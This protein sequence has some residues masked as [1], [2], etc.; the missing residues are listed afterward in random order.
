MAE[1]ALGGQH[2]AAL[3]M[4]RD[5]PCKLALESSQAQ[6]QQGAAGSAPLAQ[7]EHVLHTWGYGE[8]GALGHG[9]HL[10]EHYPRH[11]LSVLQPVERPGEVGISSQM[12]SVSAGGT[13]TLL[14]DQFG[15]VFACGR[16]E[17]E[18]RLGATGPQL[19]DRGVLLLFSRVGRLA[20]THV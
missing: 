11:V 10:P 3:T 20:R 14:V 18:G 17:G 4:A 6:Q 2:S 16:D 5:T 19:D 12:P 15:R 1:L 9:E 13:H 7:A 8:F